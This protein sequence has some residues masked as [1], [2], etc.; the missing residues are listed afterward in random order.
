MRKGLSIGVDVGGSHVTSAVINLDDN[1]VL[2]ETL[3]GRDVD[4]SAEADVIIRSWA[5]AIIESMAKSPEPVTGIGMAMPGPFDYSKGIALFRG[6]PKFNKLYGLNVSQALQTELNTPMPIRFMNDASAFAVGEAFAGSGKG[7]NRL[8]AITLGTGFGSAFL[9]EGIP[10][11][12]REDVPE[13]GC[14][15]HLPYKDGIV[16]EY[17]STRWFVGRY[18]ELTGKQVKGVKSIADLAGSDEVAKALFDEFGSNLG[19]LLSPWFKKFKVEALIAGGNISRAWPLFGGTFDLALKN[20]NVDIVT[21]VSELK[22]HAALLGSAQLLVEEYWK[23]MKDVV[24]Q[25]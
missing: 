14:V 24:A 17:F 7:F 15:Y 13:L 21:A 2:S 16:D 9:Q 5:E 18:E 25:M 12:E 23:D 11:I 20:E 3:S 10:V 22:E 8:M 4:T 19:T 6:L 1:A